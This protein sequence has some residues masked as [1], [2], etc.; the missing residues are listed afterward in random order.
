MTRKPIFALLTA[1][2]CGLLLALGFSA[3]ALAEDL[4]DN[5]TCLECHAG[6]PYSAKEGSDVPRIHT[7]D[8]G[9]AV[10]DHEMWSCIDC[11]ENVTELPHPEDYVGTG[12]EVN[13]ENCHEGTP[14]ME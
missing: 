7:D 14:G 12:T 1:S 2:A 5:E 3:T 6:E 9:F 11:H 4:S 13:C 8:G 10:E